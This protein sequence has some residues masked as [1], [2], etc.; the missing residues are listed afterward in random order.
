MQTNIMIEGIGEVLT[1]GGMRGLV[2]HKFILARER[3]ALQVSERPQGQNL[4]QLLKLLKIK[5][6][7]GKNALKP[8]LQTCKLVSLNQLASSGFQLRHGNSS[9]LSLFWKYQR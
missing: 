1:K 2:F 8:N 5:G 6:V 9:F 7:A 4:R 3:E